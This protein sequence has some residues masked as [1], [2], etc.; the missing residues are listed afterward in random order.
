MR[1]L[2]FLVAIMTGQVLFA[3]AGPNEQ[4][5]PT[6]FRAEIKV[7]EQWDNKNSFPSNAVLFVGSSSI[8]MWQTHKSFPSFPVINRGFGGSHISDINFYFKQVV[9]PYEPQLIVFYAGDNDIASGKSAQQVLEDFRRFVEM[10]R[11]KLPRTSIIFISIKQSESRWNFWPVIQQANDAI[12]QFCDN[13]NKLFFVD[14]GSV[15][16][17]NELKPDNTFFLKDKLHLNEKGCQKWTQVLGPVIEREY[18][19]KNN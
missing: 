6:R 2:T 17:N 13:D 4:P 18:K 1:P 15:L 12:R 16:L 10:V 14:T 8:R 11:E 3:A 9:M 5:D 7:F 19:H